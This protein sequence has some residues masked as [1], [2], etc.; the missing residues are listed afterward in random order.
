MT[1]TPFSIQA[2]KQTVKASVLRKSALCDLAVASSCITMVPLQCA[3]EAPGHP[4]ALSL[5]HEA[6]RSLDAKE[7]DLRLEVVGQAVRAVAVAK[8][9]PTGD[10]L[11]DAAE[12]FPDAPAD[13]LQRF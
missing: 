3:D 10:S 8:S 13:R 1:N 12:A 6:R 9:K 11:A 5:A 7:R 4:A 2:E